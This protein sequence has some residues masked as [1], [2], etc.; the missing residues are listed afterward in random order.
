[1]VLRW[2]LILC[3]HLA[4]QTG[5]T[6]VWMLLDSIFRCDWHLDQPGVPAVPQQVKDPTLPLWGR[7]FNPWSH[8]VGWGSSIAASCSAVQMCLRSGVAVAVVQVAAVAPIPGPAQ[9]FPCATG[10]AIKRRGKFWSADF[11]SSRLPSAVWVGLIQSVKGLIGK[12]WEFPKKE[13]CLKT[14]ETLP[15]FQP[16]DLGLGWRHQP[17]SEFPTSQPALWI[18]DLLVP[19]I[20]KPVP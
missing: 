14:V 1:M 9:E 12:D 17:V 7:R 19:T 20:H 5:H 11:E 4:R 3:V 15:E 2:W 13:F 18:S 6:T 16:A 10:A 8:S